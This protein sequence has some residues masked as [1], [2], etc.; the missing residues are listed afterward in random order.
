MSRVQQP[1]GHMERGFTL[2][3]LVGVLAIIA[4]LAAVIAP[5]V[6][7][8]ISRTAADAEAQNLSSI[9][10]GIEAWIRARGSI[11]DGAKWVRAASSMTA[12]PPS[13]IARNRRGFRRGYYVDPRFF[14]ATDRAFVTYTQKTGLM[15]PPVSPRIM[16]V[17]NL[18]ADAPPPPAT[19]AEFDAIWNQSPGASVREGPN[20]RIERINLAPLF[21]HVLMTN[22]NRNSPPAYQLGA[23][24]KRSLPAG[25]VATD[26]YVLDGTRLS[27][28]LDPASG[29][30]LD[31]VLIIREDTSLVYGT[32]E[33]RWYWGRP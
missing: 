30:S 9:G 5:P 3:E 24:G 31:S 22:R 14:Q 21:H 13:L 11:P 29:G 15:A 2:I 20:T 17:S 26:I 16:I 1:E 28:F 33:T 12:T 27:L 32:D 23:G 18:N 19:F 4:I 6:I 10:K 8:Q 25:T 7:E